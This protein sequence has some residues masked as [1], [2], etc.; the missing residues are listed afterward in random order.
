MPSSSTITIMLRRSRLWVFKCN[1]K[2]EPFHT[3]CCSHSPQ[4]FTLQACNSSSSTFSVKSD[5]LISD[6][7]DA[8]LDTRLKEPNVLR[9]SSCFSILKAPGFKYESYMSSKPAFITASIISYSA[10][11]YVFEPLPEKFNYVPFYRPFIPKYSFNAR[12]KKSLL[13]RITKKNAIVK[14]Y[15]S[16]SYC[17]PS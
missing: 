9:N 12:L 8:R 13:K 5:S 17:L 4:I 15:S 6:R 1:H 7:L 11:V 14:Y 2:Q 3:P 10:P 16:N